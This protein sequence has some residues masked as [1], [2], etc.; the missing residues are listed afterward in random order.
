MTFEVHAM[1]DGEVQA[2]RMG[3]PKIVVAVICWLI[4]SFALFARRAIGWS[5]RRAAYLSAIGFVVVL[6]NFLPVSYFLTGSH[7]F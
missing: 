1:S 5:G 6:L 2:M 4:Y 3:D 7:N